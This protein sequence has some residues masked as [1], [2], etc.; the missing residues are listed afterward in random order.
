MSAP[1]AT[2]ASVR[3][4]GVNFP[5]SVGLAAGFDRYGRSIDA[6]LGWGFG[7]VELGTVTPRPVPE[8]NPGATALAESLIRGR[9]RERAIGARP[10]I[11]VN[12]GIQPGS[13]PEDA[14]GDFVHGMCAAWSSADYLV[15]NLTSKAATPLRL[16]QHRDMLQRL[17]ARA[18]D[19]SRRLAAASGCEVPLLVKWPVGPDDEPALQLAQRLRALGYDG[20]VAAFDSDNV[21]RAC[22]SAYAPRAARAIAEIIGPEMGLIA[23]GGIDCVQRAV[24]LRDA[25]AAL[26]QVYRGFVTSG[27]AL[28]HSIAMAQAP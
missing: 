14:C 18:L 15:L 19:E 7:F 11:G 1:H 22:W 6:V 5:R 2:V 10:V 24:A 27:P 21:P 20:I 8:H 23:V 16:K 17:L 12:L 3:A 4:L 13:L 28:V 9:A 25:G 26:V